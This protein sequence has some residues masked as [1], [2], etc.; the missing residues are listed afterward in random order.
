MNPLGMSEST[1]QWT[2]VRC[3]G[4]EG[5]RERNILFWQAQ[6][7]SEIRKAAWQIVV[8]YWHANHLNPDELRFSRSSATARRT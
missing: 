8:D 1:R 3:D 4:F 6:G 7:P 5:M 2:A